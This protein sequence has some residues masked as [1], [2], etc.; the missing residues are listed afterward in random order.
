MS[1]IPII[2][3]RMRPPIRRDL[4]P[5]LSSVTVSAM[6]LPARLSATTDY[7][8]SNHR[9]NGTRQRNAEAQRAIGQQEYY[10]R[11]REAYPADDL[12]DPHCL[13]CSADL[14]AGVGRLVS[15]RVSQRGREIVPERR[16]NACGY[17]LPPVSQGRGDQV[18]Q[19]VA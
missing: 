9:D 10:A 5:S 19:T 4:A 7:H 2:S 14:H 18:L 16:E 6:S 8:P 1:L 17:W 3:I 13:S 11:H 15:L 12:H